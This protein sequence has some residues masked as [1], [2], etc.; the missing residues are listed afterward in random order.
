[1]WDDGNFCYGVV[2]RYE[3]F[4][5]R[6]VSFVVRYEFF[7]FFRYDGIFFGGIGDDVF[8]SIGDFFFGDFCEFMVCGENCGFV[9]EVF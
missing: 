3:G 8:E 2:I 4:D 1:M 9:Y 7:F 6:V 5:E